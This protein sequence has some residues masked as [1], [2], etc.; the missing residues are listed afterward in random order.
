M[1]IISFPTFET[2]HSYYISRH[3]DAY[4][5][6]WVIWTHDSHRTHV[7]DYRRLIILMSAKEAYKKPAIHIQVLP[8]ELLT[9]VL[10]HATWVPYGLD[11]SDLVFKRMQS[12]RAKEV[13]RAYRLSLVRSVFMSL[14]LR[15]RELSGDEKIFDSRLQEMAQT[16]IFVLVRV[17]SRLQV[18][19][20]PR[21]HHRYRIL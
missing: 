5:L 6:Y 13:M 12:S 2:W 7:S 10:R 14:P 15:L 19:A 11:L 4:F 17:D 21:H 18:Q 9:E 20:P 8:D 1:R 3:V 16:R